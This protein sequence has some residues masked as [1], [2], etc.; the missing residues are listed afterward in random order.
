MRLLV[1]HFYYPGAERS[2]DWLVGHPD[3][4]VRCPLSVVRRCPLCFRP[5]SGSERASAAR[6][7]FLPRNV[8]PDSNLTKRNLLSGRVNAVILRY[9]AFPCVCRFF[10]ILS[11]RDRGSNTPKEERI[12][13]PPRVC[14]QRIEVEPSNCIKVTSNDKISKKIIT[15][16]I[17]FNFY[18]NCIGTS[19]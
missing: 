3:L 6:R 17:I 4:S 11:I 2:P 10:G 18:R 9:G 7:E 12:G 8:D 1:I 13:L 14:F 15:K 5:S 19:T 16:T